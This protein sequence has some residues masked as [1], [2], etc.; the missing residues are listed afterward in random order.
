M[1]LK[2]GAARAL[3]TA[4][5]LSVISP[6]SAVAATWYKDPATGYWYHQNDAGNNTTGWLH[7]TDGK[8]YYLSQTGKMLSNEWH[9]DPDGK[10]YFFN[11]SGVLAA[12]TWHQDP[13]GRWY[14]LGP[15]GAMLTNAWHK[16]PDGRWY[17]LTGNGAMLANA[18]HQDPDGRWFYVDGTGSMLTGAGTITPDGY[19]LKEDGNWDTSIPKKSS[20][21]TTRSSRSSSGGG[22]G[23]GGSSSGGSGTT[24][25]PSTPD[26]K[27]DSKPTTPDDKKDNSGNS[28]T[29]EKPDMPD[30]P[31]D[32]KTYLTYKI[33]YVDVDKK[34]VLSE[35]TG[36][37]LAGD[38]VEIE[39]VVIEGYTLCENQPDKMT[40]NTEN[41]TITIYYSAIPVASP[42]DAKEVSW[43]IRFVDAETHAK[44]LAPRRN[45][46]IVEGGT[47][48]VNFME[49]IVDG[50][51]IWESVEKPV[52]TIDVY[53]PGPK[54]Y[55][56]EYEKTGELEE[57]EDPEKE[58]ED[59][60][61][62][63][64]QKAKEYEAAF[65]GEKEENIPNF[66][67]DVADQ[68]EN[69]TRLVSAIASIDDT[70]EHTIYLIG[71]NF[72]P[73]GTAIP[74]HYDGVLYSNLEEDT[75]TYNGDTYYLAR[76]SITRSYV[77]ENCEHR[78]VLDKDH[79]GGCLSRGR[80]EWICDKCGETMETYTAALGH[81]DEDG[82]SV[83]DRCGVRAFDQKVGDTLK[84]TITLNDGTTKELTYTCIDEDYQGGMLYISNESLSVSEFGGYGSFNYNDSNV[85]D[86]FQF[87]FANASAF[88]TDVLLPIERTDG[89]TQDFAMLLTED[90]AMQYASVIPKTG[91]YLVRV[92][93][94][95]KV[96]GVAS[97]GSINEVTN[98]DAD[99]YGVRPAIILAKPDT[100]VPSSVHW[101]IG[102]MQAREIGGVTYMFKCIDQNY[103]D[104]TQNHRKAALFLCDSIIA[105]NTGSHYDYEKQPDGSYDYVYKPG[106]ITNFGDSN[107]YKYSKIHKWLSENTNTYNMEPISIGVDYAYMGATEKLRYED[108]DDNSVKASYI[109]SQK[110]TSY[111]FSLSVD[112]ALKYKQYL[113]DFGDDQYGANTKAYWLRTPMG[114]AGSYKETN[115][116]YV[117]DIV[118]GNI[119][120]QT[121]KP[122]TASDDDEVLETSTVGVRPAYCM[123]QM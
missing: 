112:E 38:T 88:S 1:K 85:Q 81:I 45:G 59:K 104:G 63:W 26:Q 75:V 92:P 97:D 116:V 19:T 65:T 10:W 102:D 28:G 50:K 55:Y 67:F 53:G 78:W 3:V 113:W 57:P 21:S 79:P 94:E 93:G 64:Y 73:N 82:D 99:V 106:P 87:G 33:Q 30:Q 117:V 22:S 58:A 105:S 120:P 86:Y 101:N 111:I 32:A 121:I 70:E 118:N 34:I 56:I 119:H 31:S 89:M 74:N 77:T 52:L 61:D 108:L 36:N 14:Y 23:G 60:L 7:D 20:T 25:N 100:N 13:D 44:E 11:A 41:Q 40:V 29:T 17:Y 49:R 95:S 110:L 37:A 51:D 123:P 27:P 12:N 46:K 122:V 114:V 35:T 68:G 8:W 9:Q 103:V 62:S 54:I 24:T 4:L 47:L 16:N 115:Q 39:H 71:K 90:E 84:T 91:A 109:G 66:R 72:K 96:M 48:N 80:Q 6:Q 98:P 83:C 15:S 69:D 43:E 107:D 76:F 42:S 5:T 18:W 2:K